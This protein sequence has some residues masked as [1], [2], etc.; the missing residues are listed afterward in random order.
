[1]RGVEPERASGDQPQLGVHLLD[2][3][4]AQ[5]V[6]NRGLDPG[7]LLGDRARELDERRE[8]ASSGPGQPGVEQR[9]RLVERDPVDLAQLLGEQ[10]GALEPLV[11]LLDA[12][13]LE[14]LALG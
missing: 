13:E 6:L 10:V 1:M 7:S 12:G 5:P 14:L 9:D 2:P 4:V 8:A 11:Q 3:R